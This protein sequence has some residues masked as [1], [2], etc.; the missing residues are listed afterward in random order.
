MK[1]KVCVT[2]Y[3][4]F[5]FP[6]KLN[7]GCITGKAGWLSVKTSVKLERKYSMSIKFTNAQIRNFIWYEKESSIAFSCLVQTL[8]H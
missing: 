6:L 8:S 2:A 1:V 3:L 7:K 4:F 5:I